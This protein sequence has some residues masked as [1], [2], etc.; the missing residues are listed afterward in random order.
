M[1]IIY[2]YNIY[3]TN[4]DYFYVKYLFNLYIYLFSVEINISMNYISHKNNIFY[5]YILGT[6]GFW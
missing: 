2:L 1:Y 4:G 6:N 5:F 3:L